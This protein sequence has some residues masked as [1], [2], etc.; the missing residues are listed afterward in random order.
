MSVRIAHGHWRHLNSQRHGRSPRLSV[1]A[2]SC[3]VFRCPQFRSRGL[4][5][6]LMNTLLLGKTSRP[7]HGVATFS[8]HLADCRLGT[9]GVLTACVFRVMGSRRVGSGIHGV[10]GSS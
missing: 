2:S 9:W 1:Q 7:V 10:K 3:H 6:F 8:F 4:L 5:W